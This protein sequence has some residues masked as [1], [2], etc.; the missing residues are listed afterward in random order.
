MMVPEG[1]RTKKPSQRLISY[2]QGSNA[3]GEK[4]ER[5]ASK[6]C[7]C[8]GVA[9]DWLQPPRGRGEGPFGNK[10]SPSSAP[11]SAAANIMRNESL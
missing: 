1:K 5:L 3:P 9:E 11:D 10:H 6:R 8:T 4:S 2:I 7:R